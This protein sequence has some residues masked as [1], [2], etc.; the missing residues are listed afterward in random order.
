MIKP[1]GNIN[2][3]QLEDILR[4]VNYLRINNHFTSEQMTVEVGIATLVVEIRNMT[5]DLRWRVSYSADPT[6]IVNIL[7]SYKVGDRS[8]GPWHVGAINRDGIL[9]RRLQTEVAG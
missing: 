3:T 8:W 6:S 5:N 4:H 9:V 1:G 2:L 7:L